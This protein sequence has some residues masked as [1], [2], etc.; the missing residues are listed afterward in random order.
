MSPYPETH[1]AAPYA[2][3]PVAGEG[4]PV[5]GEPAAPVLPKP[6]DVFNSLNGWEELAI[7]KAFGSEI[8][9]NDLS[10]TMRI[11]ALYF[12]LE[13]REGNNDMTARQSAFDAPLSM[14][15]GRFDMSD[16]EDK[17]A[18]GED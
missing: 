10:G 12:V 16:A 7:K 4:S 13:K 2:A 6:D 15:Q 11:R 8:S 5:Y 14:I 17:A 9:G 18:V 3:A 1:P